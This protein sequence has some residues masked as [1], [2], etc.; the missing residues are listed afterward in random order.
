MHTTFQKNILVS[1]TVDV[2]LQCHH[3][4]TVMWIPQ[5]LLTPLFVHLTA[6]IRYFTISGLCMEPFSYIR[7]QNEMLPIP[8]LSSSTPHRENARAIYSIPHQNNIIH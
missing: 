4:L 2:R 6:Q 7:H 3:N 1:L 5:L 8:L